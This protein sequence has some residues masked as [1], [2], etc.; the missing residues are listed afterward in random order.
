ML[1]NANFRKILKS[2]QKTVNGKTK[3]SENQYY[4]INTTS[5]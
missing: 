5:T 3:F 1:R 4:E 2:E